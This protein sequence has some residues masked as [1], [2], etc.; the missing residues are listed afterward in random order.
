MKRSTAKR[1]ASIKERLERIELIST[2]TLMKRTKTCGKPNCRCAADPAQR[3]GPYF[4]WNRLEQ[5]KLRHR[6]VSAAEATQ[7]RTA[8]ENYQRILALLA[9]W[10][11]ES[12]RDILG[13]K[14]LKNRKQRR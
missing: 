9:R 2:G 4:E 11:D 5:G 7:I 6:V 14:R 1:I 8:Q 3:H 10:E 13:A 12:L